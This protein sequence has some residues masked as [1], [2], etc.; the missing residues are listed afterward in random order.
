MALAF[1]AGQQVTQV[2]TPIVGVVKEAKI[3]DGDQV[4]YVVSYTDSNGVQHER[5][6]NENEIK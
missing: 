1:K 2:V 6:F 3:V 5:T 4:V